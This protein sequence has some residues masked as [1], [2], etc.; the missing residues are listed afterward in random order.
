MFSI[1]WNLHKKCWS[2]R[3]KK[4]IVIGHQ[5][6][7]LVQLPTFKVWEGGRQRVIREKKKNVHAFVKAEVIHPYEDIHSNAKR[8]SYNPY[9]AGYFYY[10]DT[11]EP[12]KSAIKAWL[13]GGQVFVI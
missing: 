6:R 12:I 13:I 4:G 1:Y 10:A 8:V 9:K 7:I 2:I 3:N 11:G 5:E